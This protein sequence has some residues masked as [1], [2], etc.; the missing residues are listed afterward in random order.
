[1]I[2]IQN[3]RFDVKN[4]QEREKKLSRLHYETIQSCLNRYGDQFIKFFQ[5]HEPKAIPDE[6]LSYEEKGIFIETSLISQIQYYHTPAFRIF[7]VKDI[8]VTTDFPV[9]DPT[10][11]E[12]VFPWIDEADLLLNYIDN[13]D[14]DY[15]PNCVLNMCCGAGTIALALAKKWPRSKII[16]IDNNERAIL[17]ANFNKELNDLSN[18]EFKCGNLFQELE[19]NSFD[20]IVS[21][22]PFAIQPP[23]HKEHTHSAG[24]EYGEKVVKPL[25]REAPKYLTSNGRHLMLCYSLGNAQNPLRI[26]D[27]LIENQYDKS[28]INSTVLNDE[29]VWR[30]HGKKRVNLNPMPVAYMS[31]RCGDKDYKIYKQDKGIED[32]ISWI[33]KKLIGNNP[34]Y[35]HLYYLIVDHNLSKN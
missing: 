9:T 30:F 19:E 13:I 32:Y 12:R 2:E 16:G 23:K 15:E 1:M 25:I 10:E 6:Y 5:S 18:V 21:D 28:N 22:P 11:G 7:K 4:L 17:C 20:L 34:S 33:E 31:I 24:G 27:L 3:W 26:E 8:Y 14:F 35:T 29:N